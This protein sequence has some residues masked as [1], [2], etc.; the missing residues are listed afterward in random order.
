MALLHISVPHELAQKEAA[1][2]LRNLLTEL[3]D[4]SSGKI[5]DLQESWSGD[6]SKFSF[7]TMG[8]LVSGTLTVRES[9]V[10]LDGNIPFAALPFKWRMESMIRDQVN[11]LL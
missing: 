3:K 2:R 6:Q 7:N 9:D 1:T 10:V 8:F 4:K 11:Q 5:T